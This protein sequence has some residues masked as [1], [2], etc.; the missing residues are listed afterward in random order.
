MPDAL[1]VSEGDYT[2]Y[3]GFEDDGDYTCRFSKHWLLDAPFVSEGDC[4]CCC[5]RKS[6]MRHKLPCARKPSWR[7][8]YYARRVG[9]AEHPGPRAGTYRCPG[10]GFNMRARAFSRTRACAVCE[11]HDGSGYECR[12][13]AS[14]LCCGCISDES[15]TPVA[16][17]EGPTEDAA[18][19][20]GC[21]AMEH[22]AESPI[23]DAE[24]GTS[25][26]T[27]G[28]AATGREPQPR[29]LGYARPATRTS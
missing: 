20:A 14:L 3:F 28:H 29:S 13:C 9:D 1:F 4:T 11:R 24:L 21:S 16:A 6:W 19:D 7:P 18:A 10:C 12:A 22:T 17:A 27:T 15:M 23:E 5:F 2:C 26:A 8:W 25:E